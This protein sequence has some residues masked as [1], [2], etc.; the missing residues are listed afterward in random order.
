LQKNIVLF[1]AK[2]G[3]KI[4]NHIRIEMN[5]HQKSVW[6][7]IDALQAKGVIAKLTMKE[8]TDDQHPLYWLSTAG[9]FSAVAE[10]ADSKRLLNRTLDVYPDNKMLQCLVE[11]SIFLGADVCKIGYLSILRPKRA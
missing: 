4:K 7:A 11:L 2:S 3:P 8:P 6:A 1:L 10:G 9:V 5:Q